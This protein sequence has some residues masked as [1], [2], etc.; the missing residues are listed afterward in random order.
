M[1]PL[2]SSVILLKVTLSGLVAPVIFPSSVRDIFVS[3]TLRPS[4]SSGALLCLRLRNLSWRT[5]WL[6]SNYLKMKK[7]LRHRTLGGADAAHRVAQSK[8]RLIVWTSFKIILSVYFHAA[9]AAT[10]FSRLKRSGFTRDIISC[11]STVLLTSSMPT[12]RFPVFRL[13]TLPLPT[14]HNS[15]AYTLISR[16]WL[17]LKWLISFGLGDL[18]A[19][20]QEKQGRERIRAR[21]LP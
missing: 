13:P 8:R 6:E 3:I 5:F 20:S 2:I 4:V 15:Y 1:R 17:R 12:S 10:D 16:S 14:T 9:P 18:M 7:L 21:A 19:R 11:V